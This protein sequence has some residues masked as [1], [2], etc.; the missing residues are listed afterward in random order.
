MVLGKPEGPWGGVVIPCSHPMPICGC[1]YVNTG[2][3]GVDV[4]LV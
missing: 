4:G 2:H 1:D 3:P